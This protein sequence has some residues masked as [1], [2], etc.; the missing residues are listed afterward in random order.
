MVARLGHANLFFRDKF[1]DST[2]TPDHNQ[3]HS[4]LT[5]GRGRESRHGHY[6]GDDN[7]RSYRHRYTVLHP[8]G[9]EQ[10][11]RWCLHF[12]NLGHRYHASIL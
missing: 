1:R 9:M 6:S 7:V 11:N 3:I 8:Y 10:S 4:Y 12:P 2:Y 5:K